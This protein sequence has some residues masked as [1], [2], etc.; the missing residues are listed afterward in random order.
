MFLGSIWFGKGIIAMQ[1]YHHPLED[2]VLFDGKTIQNFWIL[3]RAWQ[4]L[5]FFMG[6]VVSSRMIS[7]WIKYLHSTIHSS[8]PL[9]NLRK[10]QNFLLVMQKDLRLYFTYHYLIYLTSNFLSSHKTK[11]SFRFW[12]ERSLVL[13]VAKPPKLIRL[14]CVKPNHYRRNN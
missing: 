5:M 1:P 2:K 11:C 10:S 8:S 4:W 3:L 13:H 6:L 12:G 14:K 7:G 9:Q